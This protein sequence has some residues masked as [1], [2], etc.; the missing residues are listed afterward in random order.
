[1]GAALL[2]ALAAVLCWQ[3]LRRRRSFSRGRSYSGGSSL[4]LLG[5]SAGGGSWG[6]LVIGPGGRGRM[7][8][9]SRGGSGRGA[10]GSLVS[11]PRRSESVTGVRGG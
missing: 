6:S 8:S 2:V 11:L 5:P 7:G 9:G 3:A 4:R 1:M 10:F